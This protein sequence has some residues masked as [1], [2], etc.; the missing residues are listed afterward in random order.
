MSLIPINDEDLIKLAFE[1]KNSPRKR[2]IKSY[3]QHPDKIQRMLNALEP[4]TYVRPHKHENPDKVEVFIALSG[5]FAMLEFDDKGSI[6]VA[7]HFSPNGPNRV[8]EVPPRTWHSLISL[9][10]GSVAYEIL[11]GPYT[12]GEHKKFAPW[13]P[14]EE[15]ASAQ[16]YL[17]KLKA[18]V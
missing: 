1:A 16:E 6:K 14:A 7:T 12:E 8:V 3:H 13:A 18:L 4:E 11:E 5:Q 2:A 15:D 17:A 9:Q 10:T